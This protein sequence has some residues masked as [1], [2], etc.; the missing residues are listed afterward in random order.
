MIEILAA[1]INNGKS[2]KTNA[3]ILEEST[4]E[5]MFTNQIPS[6]YEKYGKAMFT[7]ACPLMVSKAVEVA[8]PPP[9]PQGF[10]L[11]FLLE[12]N[13]LQRGSAPGV[14]NTFWSFDRERGIA[15][16]INSQILPLGDPTVVPTW[17]K[18]LRVLYA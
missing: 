5:M 15:A 10:G 9:P 2:E 16:V 8:E 12:G 4:I 11:G 17:N 18:L 14:A 1:I 3:R 6:F 13:S 7:V